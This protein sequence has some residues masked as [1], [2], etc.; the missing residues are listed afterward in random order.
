[1]SQDRI[2][3]ERHDEWALIRMTRADK[4]NAVD[5]AMR[6]ALRSALSELEGSAR[7]IVLTGS[8]QSFCSGLDLKEREA[9]KALGND[10]AAQEWIDLN[11]SIRRHPAI[12][13][14]AV[15]GLALGG[16]ATLITTCDLAIAGTVASIGCPEMGFATY[17]AMAGPGLQFSLS[18]KQA[19]W[20]ILTT[21]RINAHTAAAWGLVN[22]LAEDDQLV[23]RASELAQ[24][25][26]KF[27][28]V[29]LAE[30]KRAIDAI[31]FEHNTWARALRF[32]QEVNQT[33]RARTDAAAVGAKRFA[34][35]RGNSGQ[36]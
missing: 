19:A 25:L 28:P 22:E 18:R 9:D 2:S 33:I 10:T 5:R 17:P 12:F 23:S 24:Q 34:A 16:G 14:A 29:A 20:L 15:N 27:D 6:T 8:G 32:G 36:G 3:V 4:R 21:S 26:S 35:G 13:I 30:A 1:M 7:A 31:P 11:L